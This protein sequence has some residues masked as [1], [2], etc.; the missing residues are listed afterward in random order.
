MCIEMFRTRIMLFGTAFVVWLCC[1]HLFGGADG[2][3][4]DPV[5]VTALHTFKQSL[6]DPNQNLS[7]W[8]RGDPCMSN[9]TGV[10]CFNMIMDDG[11]L[12]VEELLLQNMNLS[13]SLSPELHRLSYMKRLNVMWNKISGNIPK[14]IG[15]ITSLILLLLSGN[16]LTGSLPEEIGYLPNLD[17]IQIDENQIS[18]PIPK[19]FANLNKTMHFHMNNNSISGQI[20]PELSSLPELVHLLLDNNNLSGY[21]P[22]ELANMPK[23][24]IVQLDNNHFDGATIPATYGN[25]PHLTKFD[26][27]NNNLNGTFPGIFSGLPQLQR[28][29]LANNSLSGS[30]PSNIWENRTS[31]GTKRLIVDLQ[32]N[33]L[34]NI[35]GSYNLPPNVTVRL[36]GNPICLNTNLVQ[37]CGSQNENDSNIQSSTNSNVACFVQSCPPPYEYVPSSLVPCF[38]AVPLIVDYRL[39]SPGF[40]DFR[41]YTN[42]FEEYLTS[43]LELK[44]YQLDIATTPMWETGHRLGMYLKI[45]PVYIDNTHHLFN[46]SEVLRIRGL[47]TRWEIRDLKI[48]GPYEVLNFILLDPYK[49]ADLSSSKS[50]ISKVALIGIALGT[51]A[52][53]VTL[54]AI[55]SHL[56]LRLNTR[57]R[58]T[59]SRRHLCEYLTVTIICGGS[60]IYHDSPLFSS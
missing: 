34:S 47:F 24:Q 58:H 7:N 50:G 31:N 20:P 3:V 5:E 44:A 13:G 56:I 18:G 43:R 57:K 30:I 27:S 53:A 2:Q 46:S 22:P 15:N 54:S 25:M 42:L 52:G 36:Q 59:S 9:W 37:F 29:A 35:S 21:L 19:S 28:L 60:K 38:C 10:L 41:P 32:N 33:M 55:V 14:E 45:F 6:I 12:H 40:S 8:N 17:R 26:L 1:S 49:D 48:F 51:I 16:Q 39:K 11:Y 23:L 4:T